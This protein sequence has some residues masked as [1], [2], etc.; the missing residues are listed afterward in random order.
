MPPRVALVPL[1]LLQALNLMSPKYYNHRRTAFVYIATSATVAAIALIAMLSPLRFLAR[2]RSRTRLAQA[3]VHRRSWR[4]SDCHHCL[5]RLQ[6]VDHR[7]RVCAPT[8][9][10]EPPHEDDAAG[11]GRRGTAL[12]AT[13]PATR[14]QRF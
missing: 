10:D 12:E 7:R 1:Q 3:V 2:S 8:A 6:G 13:P 9:H 4:D 14:R 11:A 5:R